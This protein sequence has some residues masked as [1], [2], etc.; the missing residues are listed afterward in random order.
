MPTT[1]HV[2]LWGLEIF[3]AVAETGS[4]SHASEQLSVSSATVSQQITNLEQSLGLKLLDRM[5]RPIVPTPAGRIALESAERIIGDIRLMKARLTDWSISA[6]PSLRFAM[7]DE[8]EAGVTPDLASELTRQYRDGSFEMWSGGTRDCMEALA[9][10][11]ADLVVVARTDDLDDSFEQH[12]LLRE[13]FVLVTSPGLLKTGSDPMD[14]LRRSQLIRYARYLPMARMVE[15]HLGRVKLKAPKTLEFDSSYS[16]FAALKQAKGWTLSTPLSYAQC[17]RFHGELDVIKPPFPGLSRTI[18]LLA[19]KDELGE[20]P[21][22]FAN[23]M[24]RLIRKQYFA[25]GALHETIGNWLE[26]LD[27]PDGQQSV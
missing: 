14:V 19:R 25:E 27:D 3:L 15:A 16:V 8:F 21:R 9:N 17:Q 12:D 10:R 23:L 6:L 5:A 22:E 20:L 4:I 26:L 18:T 24:R 1:N 11:D 2:T 13:Q 7:I